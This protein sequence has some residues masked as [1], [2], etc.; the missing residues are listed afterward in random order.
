[1]HHGIKKLLL[2]GAGH[3][4]VQVLAQLA[5]QRPADLD[6]T[7]LTPYPYQ[8]CSAM[9]PG[10]VAGRYSEADCQI[11]L[12][13]LMRA[14]GA[15]WLQGRCTGLDAAAQTVMAASTGKN[16]A[17]P[18]ELRYDLL[19]I[20]TGAVIDRSRL[21]AEMPGASER[22]LIVRPIEVFAGLWPRVLDMAR[23][24]PLSIAVIGAGATGVELLFAAEQRLREAGFQATQFTLLTGD[25]D[26]A[27]HYPAGVRRRVLRRL[28]QRG[29]TVLRETCTGIGPQ[30][31]Q[32]GSGATLLCDVPLLAI[33]AHAPA[34]LQGSGLALSDTGQVLV[35]AFQ[36][37]PSHANVFAAGDVCTRADRPHAQSGVYA[38]R[39]GPPLTA[40][41]LAAHE[42]QSL[43]AHHPPANTLNLISCG[44]GHAI[45]TWG[46]LH[47]EGAWAWR[48]KDRIDRAFM[49]R[50]TPPATAP[51]ADHAQPQPR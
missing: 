17:L 33:G 34:W 2:L 44:A 20:D 46:P 41:L 14:A 11:P 35:N 10:L 29:I 49:A 23:G 18:P 37:S 40:N 13:P 42:G 4:H 48:W 26:I 32:L 39:A 6:V 27:A 43:K 31:L 12:E 15:K 5:R 3:A 9:L 24:K 25:A 45:A 38:V 50:Y 30:G 16:K 1:M 51:R 22:A 36:Q 8:T 47:A 19:S 28:K 7:V 21:E